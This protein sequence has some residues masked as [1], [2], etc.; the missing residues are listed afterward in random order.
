MSGFRQV[1]V[2]GTFDPWHEGHDFFLR[3]ARA[4]GDKLIVVVARDS[5]VKERKN[6]EPW[7]NE[8]VRRQR[9]AVCPSADKVLLGDEWPAEDP[10]ALLIRLDYEI[11]A[12]GYD[13]QPGED[14]IRQYLDSHG[15][16]LVKIVR[17]G[18]FYPERYKS[19]LLR[20]M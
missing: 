12:L 3:Q 7:E 8:E 14:D 17:L 13:Q 15:K 5:N 1:L 16:N 6:R 4:L 9:V 20:R 19:S 10:Y 2:F 18:S 11:L